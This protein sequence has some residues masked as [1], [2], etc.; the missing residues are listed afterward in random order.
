MPSQSAKLRNGYK[1]YTE[2]ELTYIKNNYNTKTYKQIANKLGRTKAAISAKM[3]QLG[4]K[5]DVKKKTI[6][7]DSFEKLAEVSQG[8]NVPAKTSESL[9]IVS[10]DGQKFGDVLDMVKF[11]ELKR[12]KYKLQ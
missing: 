12:F 10:I 7:I 9:L 8:L 4:V 5:K 2:E 6:M 3:F 1:P 11:L